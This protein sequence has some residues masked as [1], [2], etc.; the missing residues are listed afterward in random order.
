VG[1]GLKVDG[2]FAQSIDLGIE[3]RAGYGM[4]D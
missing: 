3:L 2:C 4:F 1:M